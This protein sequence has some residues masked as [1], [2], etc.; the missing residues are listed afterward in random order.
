MGS[1]NSS[2]FCNKFIQGT[3]RTEVCARCERLP[4]SELPCLFCVP[5]AGVY[6]RLPIEA[7]QYDISS[8]GAD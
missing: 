8:E 6:Q 3:K 4:L 1:K 2:T 5:E 7:P